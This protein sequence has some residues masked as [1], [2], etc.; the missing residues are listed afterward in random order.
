MKEKD[1]LQ[2]SPEHFP[3]DDP[4]GRD[5]DDG[6]GDDGDDGGGPEGEP[7]LRETEKKEEAER[8]LRNEVDGS[9][10]LPPP[11]RLEVGKVED[12]VTDDKYAGI[13]PFYTEGEAGDGKV[14]INE[15]G[16]HVKLNKKRA[17]SSC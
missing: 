12:D 8:R 15:I 7:S 3:I 2:G 14:Y 11:V 9:G 1:R 16:E 5:G 6:D 10:V 17:S 13:P 4:S